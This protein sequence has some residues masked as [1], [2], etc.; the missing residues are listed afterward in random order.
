MPIE[1][2]LL[3]FQVKLDELQV[4]AGHLRSSQAFSAVVLAASVFLFAAL[5]YLAVRQGRM[6]FW[7]PSVSLPIAALSARH[8]KRTGDA[9]VKVS[10]LTNW[11]SRAVDRVQ[12]RWPGAGIKGEELGDSNHPYAQGLQLFG[13]GSLFE[14]LCTARTVVGRR[15]LAAFLLE[16]PPA[17]ETAARQDAIRELRPRLDLREQVALLGE[18]FLDARAVHSRNRSRNSDRS[19]GRH[20][21]AG[22]LNLSLLDRLGKRR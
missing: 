18:E 2:V 17:E 8:Y 4:S 3:A 11:Y 12:G 1:A 22:F 6:P 7:Y 10:R 5:A 20:R 16:A 13:E 14:L 19:I 15:R 9:A 21:T